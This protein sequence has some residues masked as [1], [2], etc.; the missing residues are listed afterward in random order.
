M[1]YKKTLASRATIAAF[2]M[3]A[4]PRGQRIIEKTFMVANRNPNRGGVGI[5]KDAG[6]YVPTLFRFDLSVTV[7]LW[8]SNKIQSKRGA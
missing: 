1:A 5:W 2:L 6:A 3:Q 7:K 4:H 8:R